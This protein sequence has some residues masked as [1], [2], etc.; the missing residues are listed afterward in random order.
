M[1]DTISLKD[2]RDEDKKQDIKDQLNIISKKENC[3][4]SKLE[5]LQ[6]MI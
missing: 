5:D 1:T 3:L 4:Q 2:I 6:Q